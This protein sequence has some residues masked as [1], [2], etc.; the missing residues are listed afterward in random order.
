MPT[1]EITENEWKE[2]FQDFSRFHQGWEITVD[3]FSRAL[4]AQK[5]A[6]GMV[7]GGLVVEPRRD[8][9]VSIEMMLGETTE[10]HLTHTIAAPTRVRFASEG[11]TEVLQIED[12]NNTTVL[13]SCRRSALPAR[14]AYGALQET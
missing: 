3:I 13:I 5:E 9:R 1:R 7:F 6:H 12:E 14:R 10:N 11:E 2:F 8:G 4:G